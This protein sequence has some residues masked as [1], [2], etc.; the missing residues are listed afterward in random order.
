MSNSVLFKRFINSILA[1]KLEAK[2]HNGYVFGARQL[3][4]RI[5]P[6]LTMYTKE[7]CSLCDDARLILEEYKHRYRFEEVYITDKG[8]EEWYMKYKYDI[9]VFHLNGTFLMKHRVDRNL[10]EERLTEYEKK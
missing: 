5:L 1:T 9:P 2:C 7:E 3:C 4:S 6:T 10:L 8:N